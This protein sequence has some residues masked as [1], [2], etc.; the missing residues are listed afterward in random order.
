MVRSRTAPVGWIGSQQVSTKKFIKE[1]GLDE[2]IL[3][4][5]IYGAPKGITYNKLD[6]DNDQ[7][8]L[9]MVNDAAKLRY[10]YNAYWELKSKRAWDK[11]FEHAPPNDLYLVFMMSRGKH[12]KLGFG[13]DTSADKIAHYSCVANIYDPKTRKIIRRYPLYAED[14]VQDDVLEN[15]WDEYSDEQMQKVRK[16]LTNGSDKIAMK[17]I[18]AFQDDLSKKE[19]K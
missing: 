10:N 13:I 17:F 3:D 12:G 7:L 15:T 14:P 16:I 6:L 18:L 2:R 9:A 11:V 8:S 1:W 5:V 4:T 19:R